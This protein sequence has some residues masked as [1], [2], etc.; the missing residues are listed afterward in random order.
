M[1]EEKK[2]KGQDGPKKPRGR[3]RKNPEAAPKKRNFNP[4]SRNNLQQYAIPTEKK[5]Q[6]K[7]L[8]EWQKNLAKNLNK[9]K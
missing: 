5:K 1:P 2:S 7:M 9:R 8:N 3:P 4:I 6:E